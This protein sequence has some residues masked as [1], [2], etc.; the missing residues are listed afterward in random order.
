MNGLSVSKNLLSLVLV[1]GIAAPVF[2]GPWPEHQRR[3]SDF[4]NRYKSKKDEFKKL[5]S[6]KTTLKDSAKLEENLK[7]IVEVHKAAG[8]LLESYK[9]ERRHA[10]YKHPEKIKEID[11]KGIPE[12]LEDLTEV[13]TTMGLPGRLESIRKK[14]E[15]AYGPFPPRQTGSRARQQTRPTTTTT[16]DER[17]HLKM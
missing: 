2:A 14:I 15:S 12:E 6:E 8:E 9:T 11:Q 1:F 13:E 17:P 5:V 16:N 7:K 3:L 4:L 10:M